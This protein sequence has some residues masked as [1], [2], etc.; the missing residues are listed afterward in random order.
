MSDRPPPTRRASVTPAASSSSS[1]DHLELNV[2]SDPANLA[3]VR[4]A[5]EEFAARCGLGERAVG[6]VG[7]CINEA[8]ANVTRHAYRGAADRPVH[9][10]LARLADNGGVGVRIV[11]RDWG[12]GVDPSKLPPKEPDPMRPGGLGMI[13]LG[14]LMDEV[15]FRPQPDGGMLLTMVKK[16]H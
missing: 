16:K 8:M 4:R 10:E 9:V 1:A 7:L 3:P 14:Q 11:L 13:C 2:T 15:H 5:C 12:C 6:E